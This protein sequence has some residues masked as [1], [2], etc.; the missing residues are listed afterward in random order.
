MSRG[1]WTIIGAI[2]GA[3]AGT[4]LF[5]TLGHWMYG[6]PDDGMVSVVGMVVG[7]PIG[8]FIGWRLA[9]WKSPPQ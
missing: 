9:G 4:M 1:F 2:A 8:A 5:A 6:G 3:F 7:P